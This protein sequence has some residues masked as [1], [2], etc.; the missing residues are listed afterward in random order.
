MEPRPS[1]VN[2]YG[3]AIGRL[4]PQPPPTQQRMTSSYGAG[5]QLDT[6]SMFTMSPMAGAGASLEQ[7]HGN[8]H[9]RS[10]YAQ[11]ATQTQAL[12]LPVGT[13]L[14]DEEQML[15]AMQALKNPAWWDNVM[16]PGFSWPE[17][18]G[19]SPASTSDTSNGS[20]SIVLPSIHEMFPEHLMH[21][22]RPQPRS[23]FSAH[24]HRLPAP[25]V[26]PKPKP[27][28]RPESSHRYSFDVLKSEPCASGP[29]HWVR[30]ASESDG[31]ASF[32]SDAHAANALR[33]GTV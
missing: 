23:G 12:D 3:I 21:I 26:A 32:P 8:G 4:Q 7:D 25:R 20:P 9:G 19:H 28:A 27:Y 29:S 1:T 14:P 11:Q 22:A 2:P 18:S 16:M 17:S 10:A 5:P 6:S 13:G 30:A 33:S 15:A 24:H 31:G